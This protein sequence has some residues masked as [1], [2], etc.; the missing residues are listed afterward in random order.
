M[1]DRLERRCGET[2][3]ASRLDEIATFEKA[4]ADDG[5]IILKF[6]L[7]LDAKSQRKRLK[8]L[9]ENP[10]TRWRVSEREWRALKRHDRVTTVAEEA[11]RRTSTDATP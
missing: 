10:L 1:E 2:A 4:L 8:A 3:F 6:F 9:T 7:C 5:A 11:I